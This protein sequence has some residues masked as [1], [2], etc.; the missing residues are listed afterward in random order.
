MNTL[1]AVLSRRL[2]ASNVL[3]RQIPR[4]SWTRI[5]PPI[6]ARGFLL[7][8][9]ARFQYSPH[10]LQKPSPNRDPN[11]ESLNKEFK[12]DSEKNEENSNGKQ[13]KEEDPETKRQK[14]EER[15]FRE[16]LRQK[17]E[18]AKK[19]GRDAS[20]FSKEGGGL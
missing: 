4:Q 17:Q 5:A 15:R 12:K 9:R 3:L 11:S 1:L 6:G 18:S 13:E 7:A 10:R 2:L 14:Q 16:E 8:T 19:N 20:L